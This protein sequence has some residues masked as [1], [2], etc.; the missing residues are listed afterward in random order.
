MKETPRGIDGRPIP[1]RD[2]LLLELEQL[3]RGC[4]PQECAALAVA[5]GSVLVILSSR[6]TAQP[7]VDK[8]EEEGPRVKPRPRYLDPEQ[9]AEIATKLA[10]LDR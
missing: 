6:L 3:A 2:P 4:P 1:S 5:M 7:G 10:G 8:K 9:A